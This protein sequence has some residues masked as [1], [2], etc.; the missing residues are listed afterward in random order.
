M[1]AAVQARARRHFMEA[2]V[3][4]TLDH[5]GILIFVSLLERRVELIADRGI[6]EKVDPETWTS[7]VNGMISK[8]SA[9]KIADAIVEAVKECGDIL[10]KKVERR[11]N[12]TNELGN[13]PEELESG[14]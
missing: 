14:S 13:A 10:A 9:G 1:A 5:T 3:H 2:G 12:D 4:D 7:I 8:I 6:N 11:Q